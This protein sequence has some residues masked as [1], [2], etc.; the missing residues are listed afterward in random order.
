MEIIIIIPMIFVLYALLFGIVAVKAFL[1]NIDTILT[2]ILIVIIF[3]VAFFLIAVVIK[4]LVSK[5]YGKYEKKSFFLIITGI[6]FFICFLC[7]VYLIPEMVSFDKCSYLAGW[8]GWS[9]DVR[10]LFMGIT[11]LSG[12]LLIIGISSMIN[13]R[14]VHFLFFICEIIYIVWFLS[15]CSSICA[16]SYSD[17]YCKNADLSSDRLVECEIEEDA[18][19]Y[20]QGSSGRFRMVYPVLSPFKYTYDSFERGET[21]LVIDYMGYDSGEDYVLVSNC[22]KAGLVKRE[23]LSKKDSFDYKYHFEIAESA[24]MYEHLE[25]ETP[26]NLDKNETYMK[27]VVGEN[28]IEVLE[29]GENVVKTD[30]EGD[31]WLVETEDG[32]EGYV[33]YKYINL[34]REK[35]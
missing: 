20:Y 35:I 21:V 34:V 32:T 4:D 16:Q 30:Y 22:E 1:D 33:E 14:F 13:S 27:D 8:F 12:G 29:P 19:I 24:D 2:G 6:I 23:N 26:T 15:Y 31:Y 7:S 10:M 3:L 17:Y 28:V 18:E 11:F 5:K 25:V 9:S